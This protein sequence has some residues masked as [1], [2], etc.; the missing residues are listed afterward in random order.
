MKAQ[1]SWDTPVADE[2]RD[3]SDASE[4]IHG[5][6]DDITDDAESAARSMPRPSHCCA[7][8]TAG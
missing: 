3:V 8:G 7:N 4:D 6:T 2:T 5:I 1:K